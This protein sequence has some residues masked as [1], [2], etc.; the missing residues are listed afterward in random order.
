MTF[1]TNDSDARK[2]RI[3]LKVVNDESSMYNALKLLVVN[4]LVREHNAS[5]MNSLYAGL[6]KYG[7]LT[8]A[9]RNALGRTLRSY[10]DELVE[11]A[12][13]SRHSRNDSSRSVAPEQSDVPPHNDENNTPF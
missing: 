8:D 13:A 5:F 6:K 3:I 1:Q 9:Q 10:G 11:I 12:N 4:N 7:T 2:T